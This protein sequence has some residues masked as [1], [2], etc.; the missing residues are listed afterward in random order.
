MLGPLGCRHT[1]TLEERA[2]GSYR[3]S[4]D[5]DHVEDAP[6]N[7]HLILVDLIAVPVGV[8]L[9]AVTRGMCGK[10]LALP[11]L[12]LPSAA[13]PL[14]DLQ[15][16]EAGDLVEYA[17]CELPFWGI[18]APVVQGS[19]GTVVRRK[20]LSQEIQVRGLS[21]DPVP[22]LG[23]HHRHAASRYQVPH[24]VHA[25]PLQAGAALSGVLYFLEDFVPFAGGV[26]SQSFYL[27]SERVSATGLFVGGDAGVEDGPLRAVAVR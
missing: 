18:I 10:Y 20:L 7:L 1:L 12:A 17:I 3:P 2:D 27:L 25:G 11:C 13:A 23:Q 5:T 16:L 24:A 6:Y 9:E 19:Q 8:E 21:G 22:V 15:A 4:L 14:R 26:G